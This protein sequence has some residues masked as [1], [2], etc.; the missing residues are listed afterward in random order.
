MKLRIMSGFWHSIST[1]ENPHNI[2]CDSSWC[3]FKKAVEEK[4]PLPSHNSMKNYPRL[5][6]KYEDRVREIFFEL[7]SPALLER[8]MKGGS[9]NTNESLHSKLWYHQR[10]SKFAGLKRRNFLTR[11]T[12]IYHNFGFVANKFLQH[13][14]FPE[15]A[16]SILT[17]RRMVQRKT[18]ERRS[19]KRKKLDFNPGPDYQPGGF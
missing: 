2:H 18:A 4:K 14:D 11:L 9:Q 6:K 16:E 3:I 5:D 15:S 12:I 17:K 1:D 10:K 19:A 8:C 13:L 7:S